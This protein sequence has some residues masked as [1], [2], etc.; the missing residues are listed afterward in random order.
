MQSSC[1]YPIARLKP[2][3][4]GVSCAVVTGEHIYDF[5]RTGGFVRCPSDRCAGPGSRSRWAGRGPM[6]LV[7]AWT[8]DNRNA[9]QGAVVCER[10]RMTAGA[11]LWRSSCITPT[12][13]RLACYREPM[14]YYARRAG[15][16]TCTSVCRHSTRPRLSPGERALAA[17]VDVTGGCAAPRRG[18]RAAATAVYA[19]FCAPTWALYWATRAAPLQARRSAYISDEI[20]RRCELRHLPASMEGARACGAPAVRV[21]DRAVGRASGVPACQLQR[22]PDADHPIFVVPNAPRAQPAARAV[23]TTATT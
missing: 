5:C 1:A 11:G 23:A 21:H 22:I 17:T 19:H 3:A 2:G 9:R 12:A 7:G 18:A 14:R 8:V 4:Y 6:A 16:W 20:D 15:T 13:T 10:S